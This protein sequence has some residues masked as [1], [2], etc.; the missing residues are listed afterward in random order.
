LTTQTGSSALALPETFQRPLDVQLSEENDRFVL[1]ANLFG[2]PQ[3][4]INLSIDDGFLNLSAVRQHSTKDQQ[5]SLFFSETLSRSFP[6]PAGVKENQIAANWRDGQL[7]VIVP[8][9]VER[10]Q[11]AGKKIA[12]SGTSQERASQAQNLQQQSLPA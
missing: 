4:K 3:D 8:K 5:S 11:A 2:V 6:L 1:R 12:I 9:P 7:E 10:Q